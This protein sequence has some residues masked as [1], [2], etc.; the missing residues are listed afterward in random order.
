VAGLQ[1]PEQLGDHV[2]DGPISGDEQGQE[3]VAAL[4]AQRG[5]RRVVDLGRPLVD[6]MGECKQERRAERSAPGAPPGPLVAGSACSAVWACTRSDVSSISVAA[7]SERN[8]KT[9]DSA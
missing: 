7:T 3:R 2:I 5:R 6:A 4:C 8:P 1:R 9:V